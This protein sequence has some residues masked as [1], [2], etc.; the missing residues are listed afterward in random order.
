M[1]VTV[2]RAGTTALF[3]SFERLIAALQAVSHDT[4]TATLG[5]VGRQNNASKRKD[6]FDRLL[7]R[8]AA[9]QR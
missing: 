3:D 6:A 4:A 8:E 7:Q 5:I 2:R 9:K 1:R